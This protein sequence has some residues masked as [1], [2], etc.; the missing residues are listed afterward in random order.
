V[1]VHI[2]NGREYLLACNERTAPVGCEA[3]LEEKMDL[4]PESQWKEVDLGDQ[5]AGGL[6]APAWDQGQHG[7]CVGFG[8]TRVIDTLRRGANLPEVALS[9]WD[10][11]RKINGGRDAGASI[12]DALVALRDQGVC[13]LDLCPEFTLSQRP[14]PEQQTSAALH[15]VTGFVDCPNRASIATAA[16]RGLPVSFGVM[17]TSNW[18]PDGDGWIWPS[19]RVRGG[20]C[21]FLRGMAYHKTKQIWGV[22]FRNSW[23]DDWGVNGGDGILPLSTIDD[24]FADAWAGFSA[25]F[26]DK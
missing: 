12:H 19:G 21:I 10:T 9:P 13:T 6:I 22:R 11:Y 8:S 1:E 5:A 7:A 2:H 23:T 25:E 15:K 16:Q 3:V 17:V 18:T 4:I 14:T 24:R 20:H 26:S